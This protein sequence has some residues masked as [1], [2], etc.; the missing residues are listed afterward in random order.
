MLEA[1]SSS[2]EAVL[3]N[4]AVDPKIG[5]NA[6]EVRRRRERHGR[7]QL[8]R[9]KR[10]SVLRILVAQFSSIIVWLLA[11]AAGLSFY[12]G[13]ATDAVAILAVL[14]INA[15]I[16]FTTE[17]KA[18]R[19]MEGLRRLASVDTKVRRGGAVSE[20][21]AEELV[22][23]DIVLLDSGDIVTADLRLLEAAN[24]QCDEST[25]T[26]E[27]IAVSKTIETVAPETAVA[28]R[29]SMAFKGTAVTSGTGAGAV[30]G[31]GMATELGRISEMAQ[32]AQA[33][34]SPLEK[35]LDRLGGQLVWATLAV[36]TLI[37][38]VGI[39]GGRP[40]LT[41][42]QTTVALAVAAIPEGL[43]IVATVALARGMWRMARR[44]ALIERLSAVETLGAT[45]VIM[46]DKTGTLTENRMTVARL[47][48][49]DGTVNIRGQ[50]GPEGS[51]FEIDGAP[52]DP[53]KFE[54]LRAALRVAVLCGNA[55]LSDSGGENG[56]EGVGDP[57]EL[58]L[59]AVGRQGGLEQAALQQEWPEIREE[60]FAAE[61]KM[62]ATIHRAPG[63]FLVAVKGAPET[64]IEHCS[65]IL[66]SEGVTP[67]DEG[68][69][70]EWLRRSHGLAAGGFRV[71]ALAA[72]E[73]HDEHEAPYQDL[74]L[75]GL[76]GLFDPPRSDV[77]D[78]IAACRRA[79]VRVI[80][81]TGDHA[82]TATRIAQDVGLITPADAPAVLA[83]DLGNLD[84]MS[85]TERRHVMEA[86]IFARISPKTKLDLVSLYQS[87]G[88]VVA[89]TGDGVND[90]P[91]LKKAD[92]G[93][94]MGL[95]GTQV[96][97]EAADMVLR[98]D[99]FP[100]IVAAMRQGRIIFG[101]I[102][103]FVVYLMSCNLSE[104]L[105]IG[106]ATL[107]G[108]PLPLLPLQILYLN[109]ITDVFP[110]FALGVGEGGRD[111]MRRPPRNPGESI[112]N[113]QGWLLIGAYA[114]IITIATLAAFVAALFWLELSEDAAMSVAFLTLAF[115][116]LWHVFNMRAQGSKLLLN[117]V[118]RNPFI[119][120]AI[121]LCATLI[122]SAVH[123]PGLFA[124]LSLSDPGPVGWAV[125]AGA[126]LIPLLAG[127]AGK[128][129]A[130]RLAL[131][132]ANA[133]GPGAR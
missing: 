55:S 96:A 109:L 20:I 120:A 12:F 123:A 41:M 80:M 8:L 107:S 99:S 88:A 68:G 128:A 82:E 62:M 35:R 71:L 13:D 42:V 101:N 5:L 60:A 98:D 39:Q 11:A 95:R 49:A 97:R 27:S 47:A 25:L 22:P 18:I 84:E 103:K 115:A 110:A 105:I 24:L 63:G 50:S 34:M 111:V 87:T 119:W 31:T 40:L 129:V 90:A 85:E 75:L 52:I 10:T 104:I 44:N 46:T 17:V 73:T 78:A 54:P 64:V 59:L 26:G 89:M 70:T 72:K 67:T 122:V 61:T 15:T 33:T 7:N 81:L 38:A 121:V 127:Q 69:R 58:A 102:Q 116:Q 23:G 112:V 76:V 3:E 14:A 94:A 19:S 77:P 29:T 133:H 57:M 114:A 91:A 9:A 21:P 113:A 2:P 53:A 56:P 106:A 30:V 1:H 92:I 65:Q 43:P 37:A 28:D 118:T 45:T 132:G 86:K 16:G 117:E 130:R 36:T 83:G 66:S 79:G 74:T 131:D 125:V 6:G 124:V 93:I 51:V 32:G 100:S 108:L 126:S 48:L 4:L